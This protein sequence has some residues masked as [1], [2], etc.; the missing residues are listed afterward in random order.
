MADATPASAEGAAHADVDLDQVR[1][2]LDKAAVVA[3]RLSPFSAMLA[4]LQ[5]VPVAAL[6]IAGLLIVLV[7]LVLG[8][9]FVSEAKSTTQIQFAVGVLGTIG[10]FG[11]YIFGRT[12]QG[13]D[14][15]KQE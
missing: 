11:G 14:T 8:F 9:L 2:S 1:R 6:A 15:T 10:T 13:R 12:S 4:S 5:P 7:L 3:N